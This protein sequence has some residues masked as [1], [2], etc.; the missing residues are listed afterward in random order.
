MPLIVRSGDVLLAQPFPPVYDESTRVLA[1]QG[2][3]YDASLEA[4]AARTGY[5]AERL[6]FTP[7]GSKVPLERSLA[8]LTK[9]TFPIRSIRRLEAGSRFPSLRLAIE[10]PGGF[11]ET[12]DLTPTLP[13]LVAGE[14]PP[15][16]LGWSGAVD[17]LFAAASVEGWRGVY[18]PG[19]AAR[20]AA[21]WE[22]ADGFPEQAPTGG[23]RQSAQSRSTLLAERDGGSTWERLARALLPG[24]RRAPSR[25]AVTREGIYARFGGDTV[26]RLPRGLPLR[27]DG[28][29]WIFGR[30]AGFVL[31]DRSGCPVQEALRAGT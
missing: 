14:T 13:S 15:E 21:E 18:E 19:W 9:Y 23:Y 17:A 11:E 27:V 1:A 24:G 16:V 25:V 3:A 6:I 31:P 20:P 10:G 29:Q 4:F 7:L 30:F 22:K 12:Y 5:D 28:D 8:E 26:W 2:H